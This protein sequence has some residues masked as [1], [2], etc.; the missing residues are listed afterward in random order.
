[1]DKNK[2]YLDK[3]IMFLIDQPV[4]SVM[5]IAQNIGLSE[6]T[7]RN[8]LNEVEYFL[9]KYNLGNLKKKPGVGVILTTTFCQKEELKKIIY[10]N[11]GLELDEESQ[12]ISKLLSNNNQYLTL[13]TLSEELFL[14]QRTI[15]SMI[16]KVKPWFEKYYLEIQ[17]IK[18][19]GIFLRGNEMNHRLAIRDFIIMQPN[20]SRVDLLEKFCKGLDIKKIKNCIRLVEKDWKIKFSRESF[21][22]IWILICL[23]LCREKYQVELNSEMNVPIEQYRELN[24]SEQVYLKL[25]QLGYHRFSQQDIIFLALEILGSNRLEDSE[26]IVFFENQDLHLLKFVDACI[27]NISMILEE[28]LTKDDLLR[29]ELAQHIRAAIFRMKYGQKNTM[30]LSK[31]IKEEYNRVF[32]SVWSTSQL[33]EEY[34]NV[35]VTEDELSYI[36]LYIEAALL[37]IQKVV[38]IFLV[39]D[40]VKS[41]SVFI[42]EYVKQQIPEIRDIIILR[43]EDLN[44][45]EINQSE[46]IISNVPL[47]EYPYIPISCFPTMEEINN[48]RMEL[49]KRKIPL[50]TQFCFSKEIQTLFDPRLIFLNVKSHR[51]Q[52]L[53]KYVTDKLIEFGFVT[54][55]FFD[56]VWQ[57]ELATTT[58]IGDGIAIPHGSRA[59]VNEGK[60]VI[61]TLQEPIEWFDDEKVD[62]VFLLAMRMSNETEI[63]RTKVFYQDFIQFSENQNLLKKLKK[64]KNNQEAFHFLIYGRED[65][66]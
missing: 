41:Q 31:V 1:M 25:S 33:F 6:K 22:K 64:M 18:R 19:K 55:K 43:K 52:E 11:I 59:E 21:L 4:S 27:K 3:I 34:F 23:S 8:K 51:K 60:V 45:K 24:F 9:N 65:G 58:C 44:E 28:D 63:K 13:Q 39:T 30:N 29:Q 66:I 53:L 26:S 47:R 35:Q 20:N 7:T 57:R 54:E 62:I 46:L 61:I 40:Q 14:N 10:A 37:R 49:E 2:K 42:K 50:G 17:V 15:R 38:T 32:L 12:L 36:V 56:T 16:N 5:Q 48:I